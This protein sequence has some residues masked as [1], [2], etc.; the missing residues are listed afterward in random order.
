MRMGLSDSNRRYHSTFLSLRDRREQRSSSAD[1]PRSTARTMRQIMRGSSRTRSATTANVRIGYELYFWPSCVLLD[2]FHFFDPNSVSGFV[3][4]RYLALWALAWSSIHYLFSPL[5]S[6]Y[7]FLFFTPRLDF[8]THSG[9]DM[10]QNFSFRRRCAL[11]QSC[12]HMF[13]VFFILFRFPAPLLSLGYMPWV[14]IHP[15]THTIM[16][17]MTYASYSCL[18]V[19][20]PVLIP[21]IWVYIYFLW[22]LWK[23]VYDI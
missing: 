11:C 6:S 14:L 12:L 22:G 19:F 18:P 9:L 2:F 7:D 16:N 1:L 10:I 20:F 3:P 5:S 17:F 21:F 15:P 13:V 4:K 23:I 8:H